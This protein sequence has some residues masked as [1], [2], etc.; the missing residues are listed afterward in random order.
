MQPRSWYIDVLSAVAILAVLLSAYAVFY[1][2]WNDFGVYGR[3]ED[4]EKWGQL[5][6]YVG[7]LLNPVVGFFALLLLVTS[8]R[9]QAR[10]LSIALWEF[11]AATKLMAKQ[12]F[13]ANLWQMLKL[14]HEFAK[15]MA[16]TTAANAQIDGPSCF[17]LFRG[18]LVELA[19]T[20]RDQDEEIRSERMWE[21]FLLDYEIHVSHYLRLLQRMLISIKS[22]EDRARAG[23]IEPAEIQAHIDTVRSSLSH[24]E[25]TVLFFWGLSSPDITEL[26]ERYELFSHMEAAAFPRSE[27]GKLYVHLRSAIPAAG[28][29]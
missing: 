25:L 3:S 6:D 7:G 26:I 19:A 22:E 27:F 13:E 10:E 4:P 23:E 12:T 28:I 20:H 14:H 15:A 11:K 2:Y 18:R 21:T 17:S 1:F 29:A 5:G 16:L 9:L 24:D 8:L